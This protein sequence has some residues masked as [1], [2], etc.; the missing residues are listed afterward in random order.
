MGLAYGPLPSLKGSEVWAPV[1]E[2]VYDC[3]SMGFYRD[4]ELEAHTTGVYKPYIL[5]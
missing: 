2:V 4:S 3:V 1:L 5:L